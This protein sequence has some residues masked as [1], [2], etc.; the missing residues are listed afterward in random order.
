M[1]VGNRMPPPDDLVT[2]IEGAGFSLVEQE[3][4]ECD[5][6]SYGWN[7]VQSCVFGKD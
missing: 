6:Q 4:L 1:T 7:A 2:G 5:P 3:I